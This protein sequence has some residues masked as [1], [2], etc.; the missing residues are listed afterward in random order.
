MAFKVQFGPP[1][2]AIQKRKGVRLKSEVSPGSCF[3]DMCEVKSGHIARRGQITAE[4]SQRRERLRTAYSNRD[5][6]RSV[7]ITVSRATSKAVFANGRLSFE[8]AL[9]PRE[10]WHACLLYMLEDGEQR[11][12]APHDC[13]GESRKSRYSLTTTEWLKPVVKIETSNEEFYRLFRQAL[14][15]M[16]ALRLPIRGT[17]H[18]VFFPAAGLPWFVAPFRRDSLIGSLQN[19]LAYPEFA[20]GAL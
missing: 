8:V 7:T 3:A 18:T 10:A 14:E 13:V 4:W 16:A 2:I 6:H 12:H 9:Q 1:Q 20:R 5:F 19:I 17:G 11:F 15:D